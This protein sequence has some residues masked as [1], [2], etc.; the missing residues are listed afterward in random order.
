MSPGHGRRGKTVAIVQARMRSERLP[1]KAMVDIAGKPAIHYVLTRIAGAA[2]VDEVWLACSE[3]SADDPLA[4]YA[5]GLDTRVLRGSENDVMSRFASVAA[6]A[7][8]DVI[9]R[10]TGDCP[11]TD[12]AVIDRVVAAF[13]AGDADFVSNTQHRS[14]P[15]GLDVEVFSRDALDRADREATDPF[16]RL[17]VSP[18]LHGRLRDRLPW[19]GFSIAQVFQD[20]DFSHLRWTLDEPEDLE[21]FRRAVP[22]LPAEFGWLDVVALVTRRPDL[23]RINRRRKLYEG[24]ERDL[25]ARSDGS[26]Q[27]RSYAASN[28]FFERALRTIPL[29][30]QTFSKSH[31]QVVRGAAPLFIASGQGCRVTDLD[32]NSYIDHILGL[33]PVILGYRDPDVDA[34]VEAQL[35]AGITFSM[36]SPLEAELAERLVRLIPC[37]EMVRFGKN[38][39]DATSGAIRLARAHTGRD[40]VAVCG[41]HGWH[42]WYIGT[43]S[44]HLGVP[45]AVRALSATFPFNDADALADMLAAAPDGYAAIILE[46]DGVTAPVPGFLER[47]R[48]L[49]DR[50]GVVLVFDEIITGF[51]MGLGG[52]QEVHGVIPDLAC[53]GKAV[54]NGLPLAALVGR[55]DVMRRA[56]EV[57]FSTTFGGETLSLAA[58]IATLDKLERQDVPR[59]LAARGAALMAEANALTARHGFDGTVRFQGGDW[60]PR[61]VLD[62]PPVDR[63][64]LISLL[65]QEFNANGLLLG[66][67]FNL[68]LAHDDDQVTRETLAAMDAGLAIVRQAL[69]S[70]DPAG[71]LKGEPVKPTFSVR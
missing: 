36:P 66:A 7:G 40:K 22:D 56:E 50:Y 17:H 6:K 47:L 45:A 38:G 70:G 8:A 27:P 1:G 21:F 44:R 25:K 5:E 42:D 43:T 9:V 57:F 52:A 68:C 24:T 29:A 20:Q 4:A 58:G 64:L 60:W 67:S 15:D 13:H 12:P 34:A 69:D 16:L 26:N 28:A 46:P 48:E 3:D 51:R 54:A 41:Y 63:D 19:G 14:Y 53:V 39:S 2:N 11:F 49:A 55:R 32:G 33:L 23:A 31:Q 10:V 62:D 71:W 65:R 37:A 59:R 30:S 18:Y 35:D 61:L